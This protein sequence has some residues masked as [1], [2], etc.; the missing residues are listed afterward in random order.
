MNKKLFVLLPA[1]MMILTA[2]GGGNTSSSS[3]AS[4]SSSSSSASSSTSTVPVDTDYGTAEAPLSV[5][6]FLANVDRLVEKTDE[7]FSAKPFFVTGYANNNAVMGKSYLGAI[8]LKDALTDENSV[9]VTKSVLGESGVA[10][11]GTGDKLVIS[12]YAEYYKSGY[13]IYGDSGDEAH[14]N[15]QILSSV[16]GTSAV[17]TSADAHCS[18]TSVVP[19]SAANGSSIDLTVSVDTGYKID[20]V[21]CNGEAVAV[22]TGGAYSCYVLGETTIT[23]KSILD[24]EPIDVPYGS[25]TVTLNNNNSGLSASSGDN[26]AS[27]AIAAD[28]ET[29]IYKKLSVAYTASY[30]QDS[31]SEVTINK[32]GSMVISTPSGVIKSIKADWYK[33]QSC[34][35][36]AGSASGD[37]IT[38]TSS[39]M[40]GSQGVVKEYAIDNAVAHLSVASSSSYTQS[41]YNIEVAIEVTKPVSI[42][43]VKTAPT[44]VNYV[45]GETFD[46]TGMV[47]EATYQDSTV[48]DVTSKVTYPTRPLTTADVNIPVTYGGVSVNV[49]V[50]VSPAAINT[51]NLVTAEQTNWAGTYLVGFVAQEGKVLTWTGVDA[52][53]SVKEFTVT[54]GVVSASSAAVV[55]LVVEAVTG[56]YTIKVKGGENNGKYIYGANNSNKVLFTDTVA[57]A[58]VTTIS[59]A[60]N[61]VLLTS[62]TATFR[63]NSTSSQFRYYKASSSISNYPQLYKLAA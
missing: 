49:A 35:V 13:S 21:V 32:G 46:P 56:G 37:K 62:N 6:Q 61:H 29:V 55:E 5:A 57:T 15:P 40:T 39:T 20:S 17:S 60:T 42:L 53:N 52:S 59:Y 8:Y 24:V 63:Y 7:T 33:S 4:S 34:D 41:F 28:T 50:T 31:Y 44:K 30:N 22:G 18:I 14:P 9:K 48:E 45:E 38:G 12:G 25:Y 23:V 10:D 1:A 16:R 3:S 19:T 27:V 2:C 11:V 51:Y 36:R 54:S 26:T 43:A 58:G 47:I